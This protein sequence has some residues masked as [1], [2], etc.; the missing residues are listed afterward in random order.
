MT[1]FQTMP[2]LREDFSYASDNIPE[3]EQFQCAVI[4]R[5]QVMLRWGVSNIIGSDFDID[6][7]TFIILRGF[8]DVGEFDEVTNELTG[9]TEYLDEPESLFSLWR[10]MFYKLRMTH[11]PSG[12]TAEFG[13][14]SIH[15][16]SVPSQV[17]SEIIRRHLMMLEKFPV[18]SLSYFF[19][20][21]QWGSRCTCW[22]P[23][24]GRPNDEKHTLCMGTG[25][26]YP[27]AETPTKFYG[28]MSPTVEIIQM[29][30]F[31]LE[32]E[33]KQFWT[34]N[35]PDFK[36]RDVVLV[37]GLNGGM[38]RVEN[39][40]WIAAESG[41]IG[42]IQMIHLKPVEFSSPEQKQLNLTNDLAAIRDYMDIVWARSRKT[43]FGCR[44]GLPKARTS[45]INPDE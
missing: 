17:A 10:K 43:W 3:L 15:E 38:Y 29:A 36:K 21:R 19:P 33:D 7:Y 9:I 16:N 35:Y 12:D 39:K 23:V 18:G 1:T 30:D 11:T 6:D 4:N 20:Q 42:V 28:S 37:P 34:V 27:Y 32:I 41:E 44:T 5:H 22:N 24:R 8:T 14:I 25:W 45:R 26:M 13:P 2:V 40:K 31:E